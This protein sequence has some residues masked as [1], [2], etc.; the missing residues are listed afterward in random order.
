MLL[1]NLHPARAQ[2]Y[3]FR[4]LSVED[5]LSQSAVQAIVQDDIGYLWF[6]TADGLNR[7][8]G[9]EFIHFRN[10]P[11][12]PNSISDNFISCIAKAKG[13]ALWVGTRGGGVNFYN[14]ANHSFKKY[15]SSGNYQELAHNDI[16]SVHENEEGLFVGT[17]EGLSF[18]ADLETFINPARKDSQIYTVWQITETEK[19]DVLLAHDFGVSL[20]DSEKQELV[21]PSDHIAFFEREGIA[22][23]CILQTD[24]N[25]IWIGTDQ[26]IFIFDEEYMYKTSYDPYVAGFQIGVVY[27]LFQDNDGNVWVG[28]NGEGAAIIDSETKGVKLFVNDYYNDYS[29]SGN[30]ITSII[31]DQSGVIW[32]GTYDGG[33]S[34]YDRFINQFRLYTHTPNREQS[35]AMPRVFALS[36]NDTGDLWVGTDGEGLDFIDHHF[37]KMGRIESVSYKHYGQYFENQFI[38]SI[39]PDKD[40]NLY[41][42]TI[43]D[44]IKYFDPNEGILSEIRKDTIDKT[45]NG[46]RDDSIYAMHL[47]G[48]GD[49]WIGTDM[50]LH[51]YNTITKEFHYFNIN[52]RELRTFSSNTI[53][54]IEE[55]NKGRIWA[56]SFG[57]GVIVID[58]ASNQVVRRY[59]KVAGDT[60][61]LSYDKIMSI[62]QDSKGRIWIG[63][64]GGGFNLFN[65]SDETFRSYNESDGLPNDVVYAFLEDG[66]GYLWM[67]TNNGLSAFHVETEFFRNFDQSCNLQSNEFNQGAYCKGQS[68]RFYFGGIGGVNSFVPDEISFNAY[69][70]PVAIYA[71]NKPGELIVP[72]QPNRDETIELKYRNN[73]LFFEFVAFNYVNSHL[74]KY[75]YTLNGLDDY[76]IEAGYQRMASYTNLDPGNYT[77]RVQAS[78]NDGVWNNLGS[79]M[80]IYVDSPVYMRWWFNPLVFVVSF[81]VVC[82]IAYLAIKT[83]RANARQ[84]LTEAELKISQAERRSVQYRLA[85]L[86][87][88]MDPHFIFNSLNSIQHFITKNDKESARG[89]LSKFSTLMRLILNSSREE[90]I[91]MSE[92][93]DTVR[94]YVDLERLRFDYR[95][96][97][98]VIVDD[99]LD[100]DEVEIPT[101]LLQPYIENA[102]IHGLKNKVDGKGQLTMEVVLE[103]NGVK[104]V[105]TDNGIGRE[106]AMEIRQ[107]KLNKYKSLGMKV[108][109]DR[110]SIFAKGH[111][112]PV[113]T[114][115]DLFD[116]D[117]NPSG[118]RVEIFIKTNLFD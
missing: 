76:W 13:G 81:C 101:M 50:G 93:L 113:V 116:E 43:G 66:N 102:I 32:L 33:I 109:Q 104:V 7:Y 67:S 5:G 24:N 20:W 18:T 110:L 47:D 29:I 34:K 52:K 11:S 108:T 87:A 107:Q 115:D 64:F 83:I 23:Y 92:E 63:T 97:Y 58:K 41:V 105:I 57:G 56:G 70:P 6:G 30:V 98:E 117:Q 28:S 2:E 62:Y 100:T 26:G 60:T 19:G 37:D 15:Q 79:S 53:L 77:F 55:D 106:K 61:S 46:L 35:L 91:S 44:G 78:N 69:E 22:A 99:Q 114:I 75:R 73:N 14:P 59:K 16:Y 12:D 88:Q 118:T 21:D 71:Y 86:R 54:A 45:A 65:E 49:L 3:S 25:D 74:N 17:Y 38:W 94:L 36:E 96:D 82:L 48:G 27:R 112:K 95:F 40:G 31:Q 51:R 84:E 1:G 68:G 103:K 80:S 89:Y 9:Y 4:H 90:T 10:K 111:S 42:G 8:N 39:E 72:L 85:S